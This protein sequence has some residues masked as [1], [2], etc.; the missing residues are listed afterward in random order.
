MGPSVSGSRLRSFGDYQLTAF[1]PRSGVT[2]V[3]GNNRAFWRSTRAGSHPK[4]VM[5]NT[6]RRVDV[7]HDHFREESRHA[8]SIGHPLPGEFKINSRSL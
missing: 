4:V 3:P 8:R 5:S 7:A 1:R 6:D 2:G